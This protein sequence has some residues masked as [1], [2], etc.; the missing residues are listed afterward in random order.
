MSELLSAN[1]KLVT[2]FNT[3]FT[4]ERKKI[5]IDINLEEVNEPVEYV[6]RIV[7]VKRKKRDFEHKL[8]NDMAESEWSPKKKR[9]N[10]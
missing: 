2:M 8:I 4:G 6:V 1:P 9:K 10:M 7:G 5:F 3:M